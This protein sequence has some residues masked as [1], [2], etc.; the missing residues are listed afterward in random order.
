[1][2]GS[3]S[4]QVVPAMNL[5][6]VPS[7]SRLLKKSLRSGLSDIKLGWTFDGT[8]WAGQAGNTIRYNLIRRPL[9]SHDS[10]DTR[11]PV[12][13]QTECSADS[14]KDDKKNQESSMDQVGAGEPIQVHWQTSN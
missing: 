5:S 12:V 14:G 2:T 3:N 4:R 11:K 9:P 8:V 13:V 10:A 7:T 1:M 6:S